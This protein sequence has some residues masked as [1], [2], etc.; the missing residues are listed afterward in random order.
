ML[1]SVQRMPALDQ[2]PVTFCKIE[3]DRGS[4]S[5]KMKASPAAIRRGMNSK[6]P[7]QPLPCSCT[8]AAGCSLAA[9]STAAGT[10]SRGSLQEKRHRQLP[11]PRLREGRAAL[12]AGGGGGGVAW[13][14]PAAVAPSRA[15][16]RQSVEAARRDAD[17][18]G[19]R[20]RRP[21]VLEAWAGWRGA[22]VALPRPPP[23]DG[24]GGRERGQ[25]AAGQAGQARRPP[26]LLAVA[27][28]KHDRR[29]LRLHPGSGT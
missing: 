5:R 7:C 21:Q 14:L 3:Q 29:A 24:L 11:Q 9:T 26:Q 15:G 20:R 17:G 25:A 12:G 28:P 1:S 19:R 6:Q 16:W 13:V 27:A 23:C 4:A 18:R 8:C 22:A 2:Q 10:V